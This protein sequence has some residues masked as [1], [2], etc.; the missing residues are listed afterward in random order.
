[1]FDYKII[2]NIVGLRITSYIIIL[3]NINR[4]LNK[5]TYYH[6]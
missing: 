4:I 6:I 2:T 1:M 5:Y 3:I